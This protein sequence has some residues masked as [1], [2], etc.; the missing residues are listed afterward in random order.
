M[1]SEKT[2]PPADFMSALYRSKTDA[3]I[4]RLYRLLQTASGIDTTLTL[5]GYSLVLVSSQLSRLQSLEAKLLSRLSIKNG[6]ASTAKLANL[7]SSMKILAGMCS[8]FRTVSRLWGLLGIYM[9]C[10][11]NYLSPQK[12]SILNALAWT[13][14]GTLGL[15]YFYE[16]GYFLAMKGVLKGWAG[17]DIKRWAKT[18]LKMFLAYIMLEFVRLYRARQLL[19]VKKAK[20][21]SAKDNE[22]VEKEEELWLRTTMLDIAYTPLCFHWSAENGLLSDGWVGALMTFVG[23]V[24][25][26]AAWATTA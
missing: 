8:E 4:T 14:A 9:M 12:D 26:K 1:A 2:S 18:G 15:Y 23:A 19:D 10:K 22:D 25:F 11:R 20:A 16:N 7:E 6:V 21:V 13:Q 3:R 24:K 5:V 17:A